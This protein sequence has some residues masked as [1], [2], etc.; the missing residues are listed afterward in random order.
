M[1]KFA[2]V[3]KYSCYT[4]IR[5]L[6]VAAFMI[7]VVADVAARQFTLVIDAGHGG[8]D[9]GAKGSFSYEKNIN[10]KMALAFGRYVEKN[11][12]DVTVIYT[13]KTDV[14]VPLHKRADI[15]NKN[16]AD[17]FISIHTN[18]LPGGRIARGM[19]TYTMGMRRSN[20][21]L[22]A[23]QRENA[24]I[25]Y[26]SDYKERYEGYDPNSPESAI[27]FEFIH[28]KNM[29]K[30]VELAKH[31]QKSVCSTAN[32]PDKGVKQDVFLVLRE[33]S[34][35]AC[36]IE[37]GFITTPDE[38][39]LLNDDASIDNIARGIYNAFAKYKNDNYSGVNVPLVAPKESDKVSL[40]T[41]IPQD[42]ADKQ[43][44]R[45]AARNAETT[46]SKPQLATSQPRRAAAKTV[47][48]PAGTS[49]ADDDDA[50]VFKVQIM[51]NATKEAKNSPR[52]KGYDGI[53]MYEEGGMYKYTIGASTNY[54][55]INRLRASLATEFP[56]CFVVAFRN[57]SK[58]NI[59]EAIRIFKQRR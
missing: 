39:R 41:L 46:A 53:D 43:K 17:V 44:N 35:P 57:G 19:E 30:S 14:F 2:E 8:H 23:A 40:P 59:T 16:R 25:T 6:L 50:P 10:L 27:M 56:G 11:C 18:A 20:E 3:K 48:A 1:T 29:A 9:A 24:V 52:F 7:L 13:R 26:E 54:N 21:K 47:N 33:T 32:R 4:L 38:E 15:A 37:L 49:K 12:P 22:S 55:A 58:M 42:D 5:A 28:D 31:V 34:M 51:A 36:L 45:N